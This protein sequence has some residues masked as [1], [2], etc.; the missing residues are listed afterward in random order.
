MSFLRKFLLSFTVKAVLLLMIFGILFCS[1]SSERRVVE[2]DD[3][4]GCEPKRHASWAE[5]ILL[6]L[7]TML[8]RYGLKHFRPARATATDTLRMHLGCT[9]T[10][11][12]RVTSALGAL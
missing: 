5:P 9:L 1:G 7:A 2:D 4:L 11:I 8:E 12:L 3:C 6:F 10:G